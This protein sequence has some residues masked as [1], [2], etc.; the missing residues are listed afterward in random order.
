MNYTLPIEIKNLKF[1]HHQEKFELEAGGSLQELAIGYHTFGKL[2]EAKNNVIWICHA[3]TANSDV[4][5]WWSGLF[6]VGNVFDPEK[7]FI[8]CANILG[9][10]YGSTCPRSI[11]PSTGK[12]YG[13]EFPKISLRDMAKAHELLR[14]HLQIEKI[15]LCIGGSCGGHQVLEF[16]FLQKENINN[17]AL[18]VCGARESAWAISTHEA[19][20]LAI[21]ADH[22]WKENH[23][24]AGKKGLRAARGMGLLTY[25]TFQS[26]IERQTDGDDKMDNFKAASYISYQGQKLEKRFHAQCYWYLTKAL[27]TFNMGRDRG[28]I[29]CALSELKMPALVISVD[30]DLL[31]PPSQQNELAAHLP[32][33]TL[34]LIESDFGHDG[35]LIEFEKI[36]A[37]IF[38]WWK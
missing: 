7:Y 13:M 1:F 5:D 24:T 27:D 12:P 23:E 29:A 26:Y 2:N 11:A 30:S 38:D 33:S 34:R 37:A 8:V 35:F 22:T 3:L 19:Q 21:E 18:L 36:Q 31:I 17:I 20:R 6:G 25:R 15:E 4:S 10:C 28:G 14:K 32:N 16:A 9:S